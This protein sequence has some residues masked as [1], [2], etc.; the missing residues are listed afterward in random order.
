MITPLDC[1]TTAVLKLG[2][3]MEKI[4]QVCRDMSKVKQIMT[5]SDIAHHLAIGAL[6]KSKDP[7]PG[8]VLNLSLEASKRILALSQELLDKIEEN[9]ADIKTKQEIT[10]KPQKK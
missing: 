3:I 8:A 2:V 9:N 4:K 5:F 10:T 1:N 6:T 7:L